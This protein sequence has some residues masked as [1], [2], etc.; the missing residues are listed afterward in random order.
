M[1]CFCKD[2]EEFLSAIGRVYMN[3]ELWKKYVGLLEEI[4]YF[5]FFNI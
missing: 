1:F 5:A 2:S 3:T 4:M